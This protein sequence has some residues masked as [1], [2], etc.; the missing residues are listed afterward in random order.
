M[1]A[2]DNVQ[3]VVDI[4]IPWEKFVQWSQFS[5]EEGLDE[6]MKKKVRLQI[7]I[8]TKSQRGQ[9]TR[10]E[11]FPLSPS[12]LKYLNFKYVNNFPKVEMIIFDKNYLGI[13]LREQKYL[14]D[15]EWLYSNNPFIVEIANKYF[16]K[17]WNS[18]KEI[19]YQELCG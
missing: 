5:L 18:A 3:N 11:I 9:L 7:I 15:M 4:I 17:F 16:E 6:L 14:K 12:K 19:R 13:S 10:P 1:R 2:W 8:E